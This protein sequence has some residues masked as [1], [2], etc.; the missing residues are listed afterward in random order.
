MI[1][2]QKAILK[3]LKDSPLLAGD[4]PEAPVFDRRVFDAVPESGDEAALRFD[5]KLGH[6]YEQALEHLLTVTPSLQVLDSH[7]QVFDEEQRTIGELDFILFDETRRRHLHLELAVKFYLAVEE[8]DGWHFP[9]PDPRDH[10]LRKVEKMR[11]HQF[12][13]S[14][15]PEAKALLKD[16]FDIGQIDVRQLIYGCLFLPMDIPDAPDVPFMASGHRTGRWLY[17]RH[18]PLHFPDVDPDRDDVLIIPKPLWPVPPSVQTEALYQQASV[19]VLMAQA[20]T[21]C[22]MFTFTGSKNVWFLVPDDWR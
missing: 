18:W 8:S 22:T 1:S 19:A 16:R 14:T 15:R 20:R 7:V 11:M 3:S 2:K 21:H 9:G 13:L 6:L 5:Q 12:G 4:F 10:W 17:R